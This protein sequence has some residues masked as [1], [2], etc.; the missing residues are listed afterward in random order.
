[1]VKEN[2]ERGNGG[3]DAA[4]GGEVGGEVDFDFEGAHA[5]EGGNFS[6]KSTTPPDIFS[7]PEYLEPGLRALETPANY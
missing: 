4:N 7:L 6:N 5:E 3:G 1:M 2:E